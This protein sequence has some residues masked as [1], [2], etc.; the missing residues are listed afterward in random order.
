MEIP[1]NPKDSTPIYCSSC[2]AYLGEWGDLQEDF[3]RQAFGAQA[4]DLN[5]GNIIKK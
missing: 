5:N 3:F 2:G 4:F 1:D